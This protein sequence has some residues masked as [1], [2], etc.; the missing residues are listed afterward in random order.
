MPTLGSVCESFAPEGSGSLYGRLPEP[1]HSKADRCRPYEAADVL[2]RLLRAAC[3]ERLTDVATTKIPLPWSCSVRGAKHP[4]C[5]RVHR[6]RQ[7]VWNA[8]ISDI[9]CSQAVARRWSAR[10]R[11]TSTSFGG[12]RANWDNSVKKRSKHEYP[13]S[14]AQRFST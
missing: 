8:A 12:S 11:Q 4:C 7:M 10:A 6:G 1:R 14:D 13:R 9:A 3:A 5:R 2:D